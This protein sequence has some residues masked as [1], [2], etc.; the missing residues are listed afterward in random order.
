MQQQPD[1]ATTNLSGMVSGNS[2]YGIGNVFVHGFLLLRPHDAA[3]VAA[4]HDAPL[5]RRLA[6]LFV[7]CAASGVDTPAIAACQEATAAAMPAAGS[8]GTTTAASPR[9]NS[10]VGAALG[11]DVLDDMRGGKSVVDT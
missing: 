2:A 10:R 7:A 6:L 11:N 1:I 9:E 3:V 8:T 5:G 4:I